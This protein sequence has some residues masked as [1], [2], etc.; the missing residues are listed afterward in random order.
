[1][2]EAPFLRNAWYAVATPGEVR[3]EQPLGRRICNEPVV[4][5]RRA[6]GSVAMLDD[7]CPHRKAQLSCGTVIDDA[8]EC[9]Y[10]GFRFSGEGECVLIPAGDVPLAAFRARAYPVVE[11]NGFVFAW[12]G[13]AD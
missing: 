12:F 2:A 13:E 5:F 11:Q 7:R 10:H 8:L 9:R 1:M 6:D 3:R 4:I